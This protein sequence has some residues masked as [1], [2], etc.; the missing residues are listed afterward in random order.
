MPR[1]WRAGRGSR[2][3]S[4]PRAAAH[5]GGKARIESLRNSPV[6]EDECV[7]D[8]RINRAVTAGP[9]GLTHAVPDNFPA[10]ELHLLAIDRE[11][12]LYFDGEVGIR[13]AHLVSDRR[14]EHLRIGGAAHYVGHS[15]LPQWSLKELRCRRLRQCAHDCS[16]EAINQTRARIGHQPNLAGLTG[17]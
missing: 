6:I 17:L 4:W 11:V 13:E 16:V 8:D 1:A 9:L 3:G 12:L 10:S 7:G 15:R 5:H 2:P 14:A